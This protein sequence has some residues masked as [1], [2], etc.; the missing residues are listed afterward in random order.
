[1]TKNLTF[2]KVSFSSIDDAVIVVKHLR[3]CAC[4]EYKFVP[5]SDDWGHICMTLTV[6]GFLPPRAFDIIVGDPQNLH[7]RHVGLRIQNVCNCALSWFTS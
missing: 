6:F 2:R 5:Q 1:M 7:S 3:I 4:H